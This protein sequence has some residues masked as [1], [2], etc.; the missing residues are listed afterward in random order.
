MQVL[1]CSAVPPRILTSSEDSVCTSAAA[2]ALARMPA[3][4]S[5]M[6]GCRCAG[7]AGVRATT[8]TFLL[9]LLLH[10]AAAAMLQLRRGRH[11]D[12][13]ARVGRAHPLAREMPTLLP[14]DTRIV[15]DFIIC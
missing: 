13:G 11:D 4:M 15:Q 14:L 10:G 2:A 6:V 9:L 12:A 5:E 1:A 7:R 8:T 3:R